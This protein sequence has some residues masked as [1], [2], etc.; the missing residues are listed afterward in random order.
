MFL[1]FQIVVTLA[2][3]GI[4]LYF[5]RAVSHYLAGH[6]KPRWAARSVTALFLIFN[7]PLIPLLIVRPQLSQWP[8][9]LINDSVFPFYIWHFSIFLLFLGVI[10]A[11][12]LRLPV[13]SAIWLMKKFGPPDRASL[14]DSSADGKYD[15]RRRIFIRRGATIVAGAAFTG[16]AYGAFRRDEYELTEISIPIPNLPDEFHGFTIAFLSDI[17]SSVFMSK[18]QMQRYVD[19]V[20]ALHPDLVTV[21]GDFVNSALD[22]VYP[23][24]ETF[25]GLKAPHGVYG[26]LGNHDYY[27]R[28][29]DRVAREVDDCGVKLLRNDMITIEKNHQ[30][31]TLAGV[32]DVGNAT[33]AARLMDTSIA[34]ADAKIPKILM[35]HR[36][37]FFEQAEERMFALTLSGHTHGGQIVFGRI[38]SDVIAPARVASP[39]VAGLYTINDSKMYVSRGIGTVG[40]PIRI[41]CPP[42]ITKITLIKRNAV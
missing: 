21:T 40:V 2:L 23:F 38:G 24:A 42:E 12:L 6:Q 10:V 15:S 19:A 34:G 3:L 27:T 32:D 4:Q 17:H 7:I 8:Q 26:V 13:V 29:V 39:Y 5:F 41:N 9:W 25:S 14:H 28:Q 37:Y 16:S 18:E 20:N 22:E 11:Q 1:I 33:R 30:K 35:C 36:P 31:L